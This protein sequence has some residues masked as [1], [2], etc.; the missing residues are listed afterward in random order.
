MQ[1]QCMAG[2]W[3]T[4][5]PVYHRDSH[6]P[7]SPK[8]LLFKLVTY[9]SFCG[10]LYTL[11]KVVTY[12]SFCGGPVCGTL[13]CSL[14]TVQHCDGHW[15]SNVQCVNCK[16][17]TSTLSTSK[18]VSSDTS[19][20]H[21]CKMVTYLLRHFLV[22]CGKLACHQ[23]ATVY[24][25]L[26]HQCALGWTEKVSSTTSVETSDHCPCKVEIKARETQ[27]LKNFSFARNPV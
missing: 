19:A 14:N 25:V 2:G 17:Q 24:S 20:G 21:S 22:E 18:I 23:C 10:S 3:I 26:L 13:N 7:P 16:L 15:P 11:F 6:R 1:H 27:T 5:T 4:V 8:V 12:R 9:R